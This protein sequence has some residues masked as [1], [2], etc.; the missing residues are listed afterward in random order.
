[1]KKKF[2]VVLAALF[3]V[4]LVPAFA[5]ADVEGGVGAR[6]A[7]DST[8]VADPNTTRNWEAE[9]GYN[10]TKNLGRIWTDKTV[11]DS[12]LAFFS[13]AQDQSTV[14]SKGDS[15][16]L[17]VLSAISSASNT[18]TTVTKPLD[19]VLV[20]DVSGSMDNPMGGQK[21]LDALKKAVNSFLGS[22]ETQNG[23]V[24]DQAKKHKVSIV[25]FA[26]DSSNDV[27][28]DM[29][30][31]GWIDPHRY[32]YSQIVKNLTVC[33]G[34]DRASLE[35]AVNGLQ[36]AGAT[37][38]DYGLNHARRAL[39][40]ESARP[41]A[42]KVVVFFTDGV[43]TTYS[44]FDDGVA[45]AAVQHA[46]A[47]KNAG[48]E[49]Y[50]VGVMDD[51]NPQDYS[52][53]IN[54]YMHAVS[55]NF[56]NATS[57]TNRGS[58]I[59]NPHYYMAATDPSG[60]EKVFEDIA[61]S[62][63][64]ETGYPTHVEE[65][66]EP[67]EAGYV[68]FNDELGDY[69]QVDG[70]NTILFGEKRFD[71]PVKTTSGNVDTYTFEGSVDTP[72]YPKG[73]LNKVVITVTRSEEAK[74]GDKVEVKVPAAL[75]P[76]RYFKIND[77]T[78][79]MSVTETYPIRVIYGSSIKQTVLDTWGN[80]DADL[81]AYIQDHTDENG[82]VEFLAN[83]WSGNESGDVTST[84]K[85][86]KT[87]TYY[88]FTQDTP[89]YTDA[90]CIYPAQGKLD[91]NTTYYYKHTY[92]ELALGK[93]VE[94]TEGIPFSGGAAEA[95]EGAVAQDS[96]GN[97]YFVK[98]TSR[99]T[100]I[101]ELHTTKT[102]NVTK[103]AKDV[104]D[105]K[106][107]EASVAAASTIID[108]LGN[109]GKLQ[110]E[111]PGTLA[112]SKT[113]EVGEGFDL[114]NYTNTEFS[115]EITVANQANK[116][117][118]AEVK[119]E[120]GIS[121]STF[122]LVFNAEGKATQS[123]KHGETLYI[124]GL[125]N[126]D[127]Y[128][129]T[130]NEVAGF[131]TTATGDTG[132]IVAGELTV[133]A[134]TNTYS[135]TGMLEGSTALKGS[136]VLTGRDWNDTDSFVFNIEAA[137]G[138]PMPEETTVTLSNRAGT[139]ENEEVP[140]SFGDI[141]YT[142][143]GTYVYDMHEN[144]NA[145]VI[146]KGVTYS[147]AVY[148]VTVTVADNGDGTLKVASAM[149]QRISDAGAS[150]DPAVQA[151]VAKF[152]NVFKADAESWSPRGVKHYTDYSGTKPI[153]ENMFFF[154]VVP[155]EGAPG[156]ASV[157][158]TD[159]ISPITFDEITFNHEHIGKEY[160]YTVNEVIKVNN[161]WKTV[162]ELAGGA[163]TYT[164]EGI[165]YD[166][167]VW[168]IEVSVTLENDVIVLTPT[169]KKNGE[170]VTGTDTFEFS[171]SYKANAAEY[172]SAEAGFT[173][174]ITGKD[175]DDK[176][177]FTFTIGKVSF[178]GKTDDE[179]L[180]NIPYPERTTVEV[181]KGNAEGKFDFGTI[182]FD[183]VGTY[184]YKVTETPDTAGTGYE[185][186]THE[187][188]ITVVVTDNGQGQLIATATVK[189]PI[190]T[191]AFTADL[192][193][194]AAGDIDLTKV[195]NGHNMAEGQF[196]FI[197]AN[198]DARF[199]LKTTQVAS[200][201]A[202]EGETVTFAALLKQLRGGDD[203][204]FTRDDAGNTYS[205]T[206]YE[207]KGNAAEYTY[208][209]TEWNVSIAVSIEDAKVKA[210]TT[211]SAEGKPTQT[212]TYLAGEQALHAATVDFLNAYNAQGSVA[213]AATKDLTGRPLTE[214]E[215]NFSMHYADGTLIQDGVTNTAD[216]TIAFAP[217]DYD[218]K[219]L[220]E[221]VEAGHATVTVGS[222]GNKT[223]TILYAA[224]ENTDSLPG[225]VS[226]TKS[227]V[228]F[229]VTV[230]DKGDGK[231][232]A[233]AQAGEDGFVFK[234]TYS[235]GDPVPM[236]LMGR[237][238][239]NFAHGFNPPS[240]EGKYTFTITSDNPNAPMPK[241]AQGNLVTQATNDA[242]GNVDFG[243]IAFSLEDLNKALRDEM[244]D[245]SPVAL[246]EADG[247]VVE[248]VENNVEKSVENDDLVSDLADD[249][250]DKHADDHTD[251]NAVSEDDESAS[252]QGQMRIYTFT[253]Q[254]TETG[255]VSGVTNDTD[256][257]KTVQF[258]LTDDG[259]GHFSVERIGGTDLA[260]QF[261]NT[262]SVDPKPSS[263]TDQLSIVKVLEGRSMQAGEFTFQLLENREVVATGTNA[264]D[265]TVTF[266]PITYSEPGTHTYWVMEE[267][268][269]TT[270]AGVTYDSARHQIETVVSDNGDGTLRVKH[271]LIDAHEATFVNSYKVDPTTVKLGAGKEL[272]GATLVD[273]QFTFVL[274]DYNGKEFT[275]AQ[276]NAAGQVVFPEIEFVEPGQYTF[277][278]TEVND[279]QGGVT[280]DEK[281][282]TV[283]VNV[284]DDMKGHL[285]AQVTYDGQV[286]PPVFKN[287]FTP[288]KPG[289]TT[290]TGDNAGVLLGVIV[291]V[292]VVAG[293][294]CGIAYKRSRTRQS[295]SQ[296]TSRRRH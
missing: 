155:G 59:D 70:F 1:M 186:D 272:T 149:V 83:K 42:K 175:W 270:E 251:G 262:Y 39:A 50:T 227:E 107:S 106:W 261:T 132:T 8:A 205:F 88:F 223:W 142:K 287:T 84:F 25:K 187:A 176:D 16:F 266:T 38:A 43:P 268:A 263:V 162:K 33:E 114:S 30:W 89:I 284:T 72:I 189:A 79:E 156:E 166:A 238:V 64:E 195:L 63:S 86:A 194:S 157:K 193:Y 269:G 141:T 180:A 117:L 178:N 185:Y 18:S 224:K 285:V 198:A 41:D 288:G 55:S 81:A 283:V 49:I 206:V 21:K 183:T 45:N 161:E 179:S 52:K 200:P 170:V 244:G 281:A 233:V 48:S 51:A 138:T 182:T 173:K 225:G 76:V 230:T 279:G 192:N 113:V 248:S 294:T 9:A 5:F 44:E 246:D 278:M 73:N 150:L 69:M 104:L 167:S 203:L 212:Y 257:P 99:H 22:I 255:A 98:G 125:T 286:Q 213:V 202:G 123:I 277:T 188:V 217:F 236:D 100:Y 253:Y 112:I 87:N 137:A 221:L 240:I 34:A 154:Q 80:P 276:N 184:V 207:Q 93:K 201:A 7:G 105:P 169:Y 77:T 164:Q 58:Q 145:S 75:I 6:K 211:V 220:N 210:V 291:A 139:L 46:L 119:N 27:G 250:T 47:L 265:G 124:Y 133:A 68:T 165:T 177:T 296:N 267:K 146:N 129:I 35:S 260:F 282:Y 131:T 111:K 26:G 61:S 62:I 228:A 140:F 37:R 74:V 280:Y 235:T 17:T 116:T 214:G 292:V 10:N 247:A 199:G 29:Y 2:Q 252:R 36:A 216:G 120:S 191:N 242:N 152:T 12:D 254:I 85:P 28:N 71:N 4:L 65:G 273:K 159:G 151:E 3:A 237:K 103:T 60:L 147:K 13:D 264:A 91:A 218:V 14:I 101:N 118:K 209:T 19:I 96:Q 168:T 160:I 90:A 271:D 23:K 95:L 20:L 241:D 108:S 66:F 190:F 54:Q 57:Y 144:E 174:V 219:T 181:T 204:I 127:T 259:N 158:T 197:V 97:S 153:A 196:T 40:D 56:P 109:N 126:G 295:A 231:L 239:L 245:V 232:E 53:K 172:A 82:K 121:V 293:V 11:S 289:S 31:E 134:F 110:V 290:K 67:D 256:N 163:S 222:D 208:D 78:E 226:A 215:F 258:K 249:L 143:P 32:N 92:C 135:A 148:Q 130:E 243:T 115:F 102:D 24:T 15:N 274:K 171:N 229:T 122:D 275:K 234:N 94:I 128:S 136:K